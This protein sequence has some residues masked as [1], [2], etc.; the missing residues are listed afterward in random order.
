MPDIPNTEGWDCANRKHIYND[1]CRGRCTRLA[2]TSQAAP[3]AT[4][5]V[6]PKDPSQAYWWRYAEQVACSQ[7]GQ[8]T[9]SQSQHSLFACVHMLGQFAESPVTR[10]SQ[11]A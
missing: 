8:P 6:R 5:G 11:Q 2:P 7:G 1:R 3:D 4:C 10:R 9:F